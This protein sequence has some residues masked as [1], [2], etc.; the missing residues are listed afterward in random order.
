V[1]K[2]KIQFFK[3]GVQ[4]R[5]RAERVAILKAALG[6]VSKYG[7]K[8]FPGRVVGKSKRSHK[9]GKNGD[10]SDNW[11]MTDDPE[12]IKRDFDQFHPKCL[13]RPGW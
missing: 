10:G 7:W 9:R 6:C 5:L 4:K 12:Q 3:P 1:K 2:K 11:G 13:F 8:V